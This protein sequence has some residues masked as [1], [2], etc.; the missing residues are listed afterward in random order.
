MI[1]I[2]I[3]SK[4]KK[5]QQTANHKQHTSN[6]LSS[7]LLALCLLMFTVTTTATIRYVSPT[8]N[9]IPPYLTWEDAAN[10]IQDAIN[11]CEPGDTVLVDNGT[12]FENLV[13]NTPISLI[14]LSMDS[15]IIDGIGQGDRTIIFTTDGSIENFNIYGKGNG[16]GTCIYSI[17]SNFPM[18]LVKNCQ[19]SETA[20]GIGCWGIMADKL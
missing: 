18:I 9:N 7:L 19:I 15:T 20:R 1:T 13:I 17:S 6:T 5:N 8:G 14:G 4:S 2:K 16:I 3:K 11:I 10:S 12:Y